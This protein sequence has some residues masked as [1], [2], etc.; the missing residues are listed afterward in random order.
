MK[1][2]IIGVLA[3]NEESGICETLNDILAQDLW[4][5]PSFKTS[6]HIV[7]NGA[8][9]RTAA[10]ARAH[11]SNATQ[12]TQVFEVERPG[13]ANAWNLFVHE[14]TPADTDILVLA[15]ADIR[16]PQPEALRVLVET[17]LA[18]PNAVAV[19]DEPVK[20]WVYAGAGGAKA[21][22]SSS[23]SQLAKQGP[24][25]LCGQLYAAQAK[26]LRTIFL[27][28]PM[29]VEDGFIKAMLLTQGFTQP[30]DTSLLI[31]APDVYHVYE[32]EKGFAAVYKHE[33][34]I[35]L[36]T[37]CNLV[38]FKE[39]RRQVAAGE[40]VSQWIRREMDQDPDWFRTFIARQLGPGATA[41]PVKPFILLPW[42]QL[43]SRRGWS[44]V[45]A[46]PAALARTA[47]NL[48]LAADVVWGLRRGSPLPSWS[49]GSRA[50]SGK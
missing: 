21:W 32:A 20:D 34:R 4:A 5:N 33:K 26:A 50:A 12:S 25:K 3:H 7:V 40:S 18:N 27:P 1:T 39:C 43:R 6:M 49:L 24:P 47:L 44:F 23:A 11:L 10:V 36:G 9:D 2:V 41:R 31:R 46:L 15:D 16:L 13:K 8:S 38:L 35:L 48:L 22:I 42:Q 28:E 17:L 45:K 30:E 37:L 19:V 29:L 14:Y